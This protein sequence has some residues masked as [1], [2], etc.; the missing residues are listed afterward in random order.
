MTRRQLL[1][2]ATALLLAALAAGPAL[3]WSDD[4][5]VCAEGAAGRGAADAALA[6]CTRALASADLT[7]AERARTLNHRG[8]IHELGGAYDRAFADY[9]DAV[10]LH[11]GGADDRAAPA[12]R[13][14]PI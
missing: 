8:I 2:T 11:R 9:L 3:A 10:A 13:F 12:A 4:A 6:A 1:P 14:Q 7:R 5:M